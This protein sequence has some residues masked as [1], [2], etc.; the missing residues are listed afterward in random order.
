M[1][2]QAA[3][4][5]FRSNLHRGGTAQIVRLSPQERQCALSAAK[6]MGLGMYWGGYL[7]LGAWAGGHGGEFF[8]R[9]EGIEAATKKDIAKKMVFLHLEKHSKPNQTKQRSGLVSD[10][11]MYVP[12]ESK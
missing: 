10:A 5:E 11:D 8:A 4:G 7:A 9:F 6:T 3:E 12:C 2:R 1:L